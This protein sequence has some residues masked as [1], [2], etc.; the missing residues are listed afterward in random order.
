MKYQESAYDEYKITDWTGGPNNFQIRREFKTGL[1]VRITVAE[2]ELM[3]GAMWQT[4]RRFKPAEESKPF[5]EMTKA[6]LLAYAVDNDI[7]VDERGK[8]DD[9]LKAIKDA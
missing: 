2:A 1:T 5:E 7:P 3:N 4:L 6:E 9:I 8:K